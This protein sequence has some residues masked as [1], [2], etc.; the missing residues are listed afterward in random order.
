[1]TPS[2]RTR[3]ASRFITVVILG[4]L[5]ACTS[6]NDQIQL[7]VPGPQRSTRPVSDSS[8]KPSVSEPGGV[9]V[10]VAEFKLPAT[11]SAQA[12]GTPLPITL[13]SALALT[14]ANALDIQIADE[15]VRTASAQLDRAKALWLPNLNLGMDYFRH[16]GQIQDIVGSV[17]TTSRSSFLLG[18]GPQAVISTSDAVFA[19]LAAR[20]IARAT[21]F[22]AQA[23]RNDTTL[24]VAIAYFNVQQARGEVAGA[25]ESLRR[26]ENLVAR[27]EKLAPDLAPE[28][29]IHRARAEAS[30]RRQAVEMAYERWQVASAELTRLLRLQPGTLVEPAEEPSLLVSPID[31]GIPLD[32]LIAIGLTHRPELSSYQAVVQAA[33]IRVKQEKRRP[34]YPSLAL[35]GVGS[36]TPGLAGGYFGG[37]VNDTV[38]NFG[39]RFSVDLQAAWEFQNLG[40]GNRA[41]VREREADS[42][43]ALLELLRMQDTITA[44]VV[45][46]HAQATRAARR[47]TLAADGVANAVATAEKNL[48]GL[49]QTKRAGD[50]LILVFRP[51][52]AVAAV[53]AL[54]T[55]Y[56]DYYQAVGD[57]NRAQFRLYRALGHPA[58]ALCQVGQAV[59]T[60]T[61]T[62]IPVPVGASG[63]ITA[64]VPNR[65]ESPTLP[66]T[67]NK[68]P[69]DR[70]NR[71]PN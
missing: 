63:P 62:S 10:A 35:R 11:P 15:R 50:Q 37:G 20:Q 8:T 47:V 51:Q 12:Q 69:P 42:R 24:S 52:E 53:A 46:A 4:C 14:G 34:L 5:P 3:F 17:F 7:S 48:Q 41:F 26:A 66:G 38:G 2:Q 16:D 60:S 65:M 40:F 67:P 27:T 64:P 36:N 9:K 25:A 56:R 70:P 61:T 1:M 23:S 58:Q 28:L 31:P 54:D 6:L 45:Q 43:R 39:S 19:P 44:E 21:R 33:L 68:T 32:D 30:R 71:K 55:A 57:H 13:S 29:E 18:A 59:E 22:D 49:G